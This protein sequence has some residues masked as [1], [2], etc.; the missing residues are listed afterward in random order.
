MAK[1]EAGMNKFYG[2]LPQEAKAMYDGVH[3]LVKICRWTYEKAVEEGFTT[4]QAMELSNT[5]M[6]AVV[7][8]GSRK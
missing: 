5:Y 7:S 6:S 2:G 1:E 3:A 4:S 8:A